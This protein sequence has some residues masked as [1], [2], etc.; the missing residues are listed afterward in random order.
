M[1]ARGADKLGTKHLLLDGGLLRRCTPLLVS[2]H[3]VFSRGT[4][5][6]QQVPHLLH[7]LRPLQL[8]LQQTGYTAEGRCLQVP[9]DNLMT[10]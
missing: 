5:T 10:C 2:T 6:P 4:L 8:G 3:E 7:E 1:R 9:A